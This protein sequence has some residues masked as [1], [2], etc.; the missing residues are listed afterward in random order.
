MAAAGMII[1]IIPATASMFMIAEL[2]YGYSNPKD[3][4]A[5]A[6]RYK[7][8]QELAQKFKEQNGSI[9]CRELLRLPNQE[10]NMVSE[11]RTPE[12]YKM[13][14]SQVRF[15]TWIEKTFLWDKG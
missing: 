12:Y 10:D 14:T 2:K 6:E 13:M 3:S 11:A 1:I 5:K 4:N 7:L 15:K 9:V 8:I